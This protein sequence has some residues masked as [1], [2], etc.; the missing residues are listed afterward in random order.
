MSPHL[1]E[2]VPWIRDHRGSGTAVDRNAG[3][4]MTRTAAQKAKTACRTAGQR[5]VDLARVAAVTLDRRELQ[6][7][8]SMIEVRVGRA[9]KEG[10]LPHG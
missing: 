5:L 7:L 8:T 10:T 4:V 6:T 3:A 2:A 9:L 1:K